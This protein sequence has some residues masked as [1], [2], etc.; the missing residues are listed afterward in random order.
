[1]HVPSLLIAAGIFAVLLGPL[2]F[3]IARFVGRILVGATAL[4]LKLLRLLVI[5]VGCMAALLMLGI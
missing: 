1:M 4:L 5:F 2:V 3:R